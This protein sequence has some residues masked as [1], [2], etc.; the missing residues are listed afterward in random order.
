[1]SFFRSIGIV[2]VACS[3]C[4][5]ALFPSCDKSTY[6]ETFDTTRVICGKALLYD[7]WGN[8]ESD[9]SDISI[10][11]RCVDTI[12]SNSGTIWDTSYFITTDV[13]GNW[14]LYKPRGGW[15]Y[16]N[17]SKDS[18]CENCVYAHQYDT[19]R[20]D[21]LEN[22]YLSKPTYGSVELDSL[23]IKDGVMSLYRTLY[24]T[25]THSSYGLSTWYF[26]G[27][28]ADV[29]PENYVYAY[30]SGMANGSGNTKQSSVVYKPLDKLLEY[31][32]LEGE[33]VYVRAYVDNAR[34]V[35]YQVAEDVWKYPNLL[36]GSNVISFE[37]PESDEE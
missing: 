8:A 23:T 5:I 30:V 37:L 9:N 6:V 35:S 14:E 28:S 22:I 29:S 36:D 20:A 2:F 21:T 13:R 7:E 17:F 4:V 18:Y 27:K 31:G 10:E 26:F 12:D 24:F 25:A 1:M 34:A 19:S 33:T 3:L 32:F 15:Y 11:V 16:L